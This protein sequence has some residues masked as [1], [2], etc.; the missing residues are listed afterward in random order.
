MLLNVREVTL[1]LLC[2]HLPAL[3]WTALPWKLMARHDLIAGRHLGGDIQCKPRRTWTWIAT[4]PWKVVVWRCVTHGNENHEPISPAP[5]PSPAAAKQSHVQQSKKSKVFW[6][7]EHT[8]D[9]TFSH[10]LLIFSKQECLRSCSKLK[11]Y[12]CIYI[13][14]CLL[15]T[16]ELQPGKR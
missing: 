15:D 16:E 12:N 14:L 13:Y 10:I 1:G 7:E 4:D 9:M 6:K 11:N 5:G 3:P 2:R 8:L